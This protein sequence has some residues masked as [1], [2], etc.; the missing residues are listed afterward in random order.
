MCSVQVA[1]VLYVCSVMAAKCKA[2]AEVILILNR[3]SKCIVYIVKSV[4]TCPLYRDVRYSECPLMEVPL[5]WG[6]WFVLQGQPYLYN[7][8]G[9]DPFIKTL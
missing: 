6:N 8:S 4:G 7:F 5:Y 9:V 1:V 2:F 3:G